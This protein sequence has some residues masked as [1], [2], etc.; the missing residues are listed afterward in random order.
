MAPRGGVHEPEWLSEML[1]HD[2]A[3]AWK[4]ER[5]RAEEERTEARAEGE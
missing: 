1:K 4:A 3:E 2:W 5:V